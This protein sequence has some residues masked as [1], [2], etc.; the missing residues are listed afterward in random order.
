MRHHLNRK[1]AA[2]FT[3]IIRRLGENDALKL[4]NA[5][6][7]YMPLN[8]DK[9]GPY[10]YALAQYG[11]QNGDLM[12]DPDMTFFV[13]PETGR[14]C[15]LTYQ[16]DY[17]GTYQDA[18][19]DWQGDRPVADEKVQAGLVK[20]AETWMRNIAD[21][22]GIAPAAPVPPAPVDPMPAGLMALAAAL[23]RGEAAPRPTEKP[24]PAP[25]PAVT[26]EKAPDASHTPRSRAAR[27]PEP[28]PEPPAPARDT[29]EPF[30]CNV[31]AA[32]VYQ[33][34]KCRETDACSALGGINL[35]PAPDGHGVVIAGCDGHRLICM[36]DA[37][38]FVSRPGTI[39]PDK[40]FW[41]AMKPRRGQA[42]G[43]LIVTARAVGELTRTGEMAV[44]QERITHDYYPCPD[45]YAYIARAREA[46]P[47]TGPL[48]LPAPDLA[49]MTLD[50]PKRGRVALY[51]TDDEG[52]VFVR[53]FNAPD[54]LGVIMPLK[55]WK[56]VDGRREPL[57]EAPTRP[58]RA[59]ARAAAGLAPAPAP[60][61][62]PTPETAP[63]AKTEAAP[64]KAASAPRRKTIAA[65]IARTR[66]NTTPCAPKQTKAPEKP[67]AETAP[68][69]LPDLA[70]PAPHAAHA[71]IIIAPA[72]MANAYQ[73]HA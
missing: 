60:Q 64:A 28:T 22:Q 61:A 69:S 65:H 12:A 58:V 57:L 38:G 53:D 72:W 52:P 48:A 54:Y 17:T 3:E 16:N 59:W 5:P 24:E 2:I 51:A 21:Q 31:N 55:T 7:T 34:G 56:M 26:V 46:R 67:L 41:Q 70:R 19:T 14:V 62:D 40:N 6:G 8:I 63:A 43:R 1:S 44:R 15:P 71:D 32:H 73:M 35:T 23:E 68:V 11:E 37:S 20:F 9:I 10:S 49:A 18:V 36:Y 13:E 27:R 25:R 45:I 50:G 66:R 42:D 47:L 30:T 33:A 39:Y 4:D 29:P